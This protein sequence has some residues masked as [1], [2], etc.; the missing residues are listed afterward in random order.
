MADVRCPMCGKPNPEQLEECEFC[1][2]RLKP[3]VVPPSDDSLTIKPGQEPVK[4]NTSELEKV[5][6]TRGAPIRPGDAPTR[7]NTAELER[8]LPSWLRSLRE[9]KRPAAGETMAEPSDDAPAA[10]QA[11]PA[12]T[13]PEG[14]PDW[15]SGLNKA[16]SE[17][18][19]VPDWLSGLRGGKPVES[20]P[21]PAADEELAS[22][23][24]NADWMARLGSGP[25]EP[26]PEP[27]AAGKTSWEQE[28]ASETTPEPAEADYSPDW[29][30]ALQTTPSGE[31]EPPKSE[32]P[33]EPPTADYSPDWLKALQTTPSGGQEPPKSE[34][35]PEPATAGY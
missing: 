18:E 19:E 31:Q 15:L 11:A 34:P 3:V 10:P 30:K 1:G 24:N 25:Q 33:P 29:L 16:A 12:P 4:R 20:E 5:N 26:A 21:A 9:G 13:P 8:A 23:L 17:E 35:P 22:G 7:K 32:P 14:L 2:A 6:L 28:P 27:P